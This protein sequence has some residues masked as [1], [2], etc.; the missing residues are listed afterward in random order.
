[1]TNN[2]KKLAILIGTIIASGHALA[3]PAINKLG[4]N[5]SIIF[6]ESPNTSN[7]N[8]LLKDQVNGDEFSAPEI[9]PSASSLQLHPDYYVFAGVQK[10]MSTNIE[11]NPGINLGMGITVENYDVEVSYQKANN[12]FKNIDESEGYDANITY[13]I[14]NEPTYQLKIG[15]GYNNLSLS[16]KNITYLKDNKEKTDDNISANS[17]YAL[18]EISASITNHISVGAAGRYY[19][20]TNDYRMTLNGSDSVNLVDDFN[21]SAKIDYQ[22]NDQIGVNISRNFGSQFQRAYFVNLKVTF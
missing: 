7:G 11:S 19:M 9:S 14:I 20:P 15:G 10:N 18:A 1:M 8:P 6:A 5:N 16:G 17:F 12:S 21:Y 22:I 13:R 2:T 3:S 4:D